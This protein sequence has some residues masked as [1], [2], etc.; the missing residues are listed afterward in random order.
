MKTSQYIFRLAASVVGQRVETQGPV[1]DRSVQ[2]PDDTIQKDYGA[3][4]NRDWVIELR[5]VELENK[6]K[7][8][9]KDSALSHP[10]ELLDT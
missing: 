7:G 5:T 1:L 8:P 4:T 10:S 3:I 6:G 2:H 9:P